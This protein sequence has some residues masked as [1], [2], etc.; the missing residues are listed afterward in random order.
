[1][2]IKNYFVYCNQLEINNKCCL[3]KYQLYFWKLNV[4]FNKLIVPGQMEYFGN[5]LE[6]NV[7]CYLSLIISTVQELWVKS[8]LSKDKRL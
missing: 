2:L 4:F 1:M 7:F 6:S 5:G 8:D 3:L